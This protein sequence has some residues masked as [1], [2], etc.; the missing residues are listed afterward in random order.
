MAADKERPSIRGLIHIQ[1][2]F[3]GVQHPFVR[4]FG[5]LLAAGAL[6]RRLSE[7]TD[8]QIGQLLQEQVERTLGPMQPERTILRQATQRLFRSEA[9]SLEEEAPLRP[10]CPICG[11]EMYFNFGVDERDFLECTSLRC[12]NREYV[13]IY[14][15]N[16]EEKH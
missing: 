9:G 16:T 12:G 10:P 7:L 11:A 2:K 14:G 13:P 5:T 1:R 15:A 4:H 6:D 8:Q 3:S